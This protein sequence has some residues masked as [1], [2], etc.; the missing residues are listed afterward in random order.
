MSQH[1]TVC[2]CV[3]VCVCVCVCVCTHAT[4]ACQRRTSDVKYPSLPLSPIFP[5]DWIPHWNLSQ[6]ASQQG[7]GDPPVSSLT[8]LESQVCMCKP[9]LLIGL[10]LYT[11]SSLISYTIS[12]GPLC[13]LTLH[14]V[15]FLLGMQ[16][17]SEQVSCLSCSHLYCQKHS[18]HKTNKKIHTDQMDPQ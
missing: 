7:P 9:G 18:K 1:V 11:V 10:H 17:Q 8:G 16:E 12:Q 6:A 3:Y 14:M 15:H 2:V 4:Y 13:H 5:W